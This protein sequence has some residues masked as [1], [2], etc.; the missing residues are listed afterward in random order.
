MRSRAW[1]WF[2]TKGQRA[3]PD[4]VALVKIEPVQLQPWRI[5]IAGLVRTFVYLQMLEAHMKRM[6]EAYYIP[7]YPWDRPRMAC[8]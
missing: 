6:R 4:C 8:Q 7:A 5:N 2:G 3:A 1:P